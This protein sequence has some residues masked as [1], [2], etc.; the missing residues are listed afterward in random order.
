M[1]ETPKELVEQAVALLGSQH[2]L[3]AACGVGQQAISAIVRGRTK[4]ISA[5]MAVRIDRATEGRIPKHKL[6]PA[7][8]DPPPQ[9]EG[10][11]NG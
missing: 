4:S 8:F 3:A 1:S 10:T 7:V 6:S 11:A 2:K 9:T 5:D